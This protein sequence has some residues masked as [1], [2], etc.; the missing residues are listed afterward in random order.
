MHKHAPNFPVEHLRDNEASPD[1]ALLHILQGTTQVDIAAVRDKD[2]NAVCMQR[3]APTLFT[4]YDKTPST[5]TQR[6]S[7]KGD[8]IIDSD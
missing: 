8:Y 7:T 3:A 5:R 4:T 6:P 2:T 1:D